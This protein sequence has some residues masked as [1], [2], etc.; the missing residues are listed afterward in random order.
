[1]IEF[2]MDWGP[3]H[4][5][6]T[7]K[8]G[9]GNV[10]LTKGSASGYYPCLANHMDTVHDD[11]KDMVKQRVFKEIIWEGDTVT[12]RNPL[13]GKQTGIGGDDIGGCCI[14]LAVMERLPSCKAIFVVNEEVGMLGSKAADK[15]FFDDCAFIVSNDSPDRNRATHYSSGVELYSKDFFDKYL[16]PICKKH[17][18][19]DFRSEPYTDIIQYRRYELPNGKHLECLNFGNGFR[20]AHQ[21]TE[22]AKF[23]DV[24]AAEDLLY[25]LC[26]EIPTDVQHVSDIKEEPRPSYGWSGYSGGSYAGKDW[27]RQWLGGAEQRTFDFG[28]KEEETGSFEW[29]FRDPDAAGLALDR[30]PKMLG[31]V[32][33]ERKAGNLVRVSGPKSKLRTAFRFSYNY[34]NKDRPGVPYKYDTAFYRDVPQASAAFERKYEPDEKEAKAGDPKGDPDAPCAISIY[35]A[36]ADALTDF[37]K[38]LNDRKNPAEVDDDGYSACTVSGR[39]E[40]VK[41]AYVEYVNSDAGGK[42]KFDRFEQLP[43]Q[44]RRAFWEDVEFAETGMEGDDAIDADY[45]TAD[46]DLGPAPSAEP[47]KNADDD[48]WDWWKWEPE[49]KGSDGLRGRDEGEECSIDFVFRPPADFGKFERNVEALGVDYDRTGPEQYTVSGPLGEVMNALVAYLNSMGGHSAEYASFDSIPVH[50]KQR[51][52]KEV[53]FGKDSGKKPDADEYRGHDPAEKCSLEFRVPTNTWPGFKD[54]FVKAAT[55]RGLVAAETEDKVTVSGKLKD[56]LEAAVDYMNLWKGVKVYSTLASVP[57]AQVDAV[58]KELEFEK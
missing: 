47:E 54:D 23:S 43:K 25:A 27:W 11:Q 48:L 30:L 35:F 26:T 42:R 18:V 14:A 41:A 37:L 16:G 31:G 6:K 53:R 10:F 50:Q 1:M 45:A 3:K 36:E 55:S 28:Q 4:G 21:S 12:A 19:T 34:D 46:A 13:T 32:K 24:N 51:F 17:G 38:A 57:Q 52:W 40:D 7:K 49:K 5:C 2:L 33:A 9:H 29:N 20:N 58:W 22:Y 44:D 15:S 8:D 56:V 39:L